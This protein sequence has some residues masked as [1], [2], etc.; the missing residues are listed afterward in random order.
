MSH[1]VGNRGVGCASARLAEITRAQQTLP[2]FTIEA[3]S[4]QL[5]NARVQQQPNQTSASIASSSADRL[6]AATHVG[7]PVAKQIVKDSLSGRYVP[8]E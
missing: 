8:R 5:Y 3:M 2:T 7:R 6:P 1:A 4:V